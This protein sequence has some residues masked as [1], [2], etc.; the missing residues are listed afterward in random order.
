MDEAEQRPE[1]DLDETEDQGQRQE[2]DRVLERV[3]EEQPAD[4]ESEPAAD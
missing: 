4:G 1:P 3:E 2:L